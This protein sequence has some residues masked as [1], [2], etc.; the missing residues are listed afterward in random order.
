MINFDMVGRLRNDEL[1]IAGNVSAKEFTSLLDVANDRAN[2]NLK[3]G[4][5]SIRQDSDHASFARVGVPVIFCFTGLHK[6]Y[7]TPADKPETINYLG[8]KR[9]VDFGEDLVE[10]I[11]AMENR[12][13]FVKPPASGISFF[14]GGRPRAVLGIQLGDDPNDGGAKVENLTAGGPAEKAGLKPGDVIVDIDGTSLKG[15]SGLTTYLRPKKPG[16]AVKVTYR[17]GAERKT[18]EIKLGTP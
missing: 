6:E 11:A 15:A 12:P 5:P 7:H 14:G 10:R 1:E 4:G 8:M 17:R 9:V 13:T 3:L 16:D 2:F 18:V